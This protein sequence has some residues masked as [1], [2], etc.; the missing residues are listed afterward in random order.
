MLNFEFLYYIVF[1]GEAK[2]KKKRSLGVSFVT[3]QKPFC[4]RP[5]PD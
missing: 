4:P 5:K 1:D 2:N 3:I